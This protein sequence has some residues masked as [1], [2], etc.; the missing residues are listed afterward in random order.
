MDV[1]DEPLRMLEAA[2]EAA[3]SRDARLE[4]VILVR[5]LTRVSVAAR[6]LASLR[7]RDVDVVRGGE[8]QRVLPVRDLVE[9][10]RGILPHPQ[11]RLVDEGEGEDGEE[12]RAL[13]L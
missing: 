3:E 5:G 13:F 9:I 11:P 12:C 6:P 10:E 4:A 2:L 7:S 1:A 8:H